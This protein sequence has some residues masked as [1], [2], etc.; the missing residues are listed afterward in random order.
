MQVLPE[1][2]TVFCDLTA[3]CPL[4]GLSLI[5]CKMTNCK[6]TVLLLPSNGTAIRS[7]QSLRE[8]EASE[9]R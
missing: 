5:T 8:A 4:E 2:G 9:S 1:L 6:C 3:P 7:Q